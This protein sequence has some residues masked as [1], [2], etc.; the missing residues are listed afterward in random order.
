VDENKVQE[1][2]ERLPG[3]RLFV[4]EHPDAGELV[5]RSPSRAA[6]DA[7]QD[8]MVDPSAPKS[9][10]VNDLAR[11]VVLHPE[12]GAFEA[13]CQTYPALPGVIAALARDAAGN[14]AGAKGKAL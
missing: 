6:Y 5:Y 12:P 10:A 7:F 1:L 8:R 14:L 13:L 3:V 2:K 11:A 4:Y 9:A